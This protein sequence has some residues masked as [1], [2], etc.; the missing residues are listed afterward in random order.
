MIGLTV[1]TNSVRLCPDAA[2]ASHFNSVHSLGFYPTLLSAAPI[3]ILSR[4]MPFSYTRLPWFL[5]FLSFAVRLFDCG[6]WLDCSQGC[7]FPSLKSKAKRRHKTCFGD[8]SWDPAKV[9]IEPLCGPGKMVLSDNVLRSHYALSNILPSGVLQLALRL[10]EVEI[11]LLSSPLLIFVV[12]ILRHGYLTSQ[13]D[14]IH[15]CA[16]PR[17]P[18]SSRN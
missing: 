1:A 17:Q 7:R 6:P 14:G 5:T 18:G 11:E 8:L 15:A 10:S 16:C 13:R 2:H 4:F 9:Y 12:T 3:T